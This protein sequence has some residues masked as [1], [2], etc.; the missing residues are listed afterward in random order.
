MSGDEQPHD[1]IGPLKD[2]V[3]A[4]VPQVLLHRVV[5]EVAVATVQLQ[6]LID[7]LHQE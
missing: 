7:D 3:D 5:F 1:F 6:R 4:G 2:H